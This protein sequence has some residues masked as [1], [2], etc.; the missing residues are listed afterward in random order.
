VQSDGKPIIGGTFFTI[1]GTGHGKLARLQSDGSLDT[2]FNAQTVG[3]WGGVVC[4]ALQPDGKILVGGDSLV[5]VNPDGSLDPSFKVNVGRPGIRALTLQPDGKVLIGGWF[6]SVNGV[7]LT[8]L[9]RLNSDGSLDTEF[10][11]HLQP[12]DSGVNGIAFQPDGEIFIGG[13]F[14]SV[15]GL[16]RANIARLNPD[17][18]PDSFVVELDGDVV[19]CCPLPNGQ[20]LVWGFFSFVNGV[21]HGFFARLNADGSLDPAFVG[22][23]NGDDSYTAKAVA[24][25]PDGKLLV[26]REVCNGSS[27]PYFVRLT[28]N[29]SFDDS[30]FA[31]QGGP[32]NDVDSLAV[33]PDGKILLGGVFSVVSQIPC[34]GM[35]RLT[36]D[37]VPP[38]IL[39][40]PGPQTAEVGS[41]VSLRVKAKSSLPLFYFWY[42]NSTNLISCST[43]WGVT[44]TNVQFAQSG[45]YSVAVSNALGVVTSAPAMLNVI[46]VVERR[47]VPGLTLTGERGSALNLETRA[48]MGPTPDWAPFDSVV[49]TNDS[50]WYFDL[51][52]PLPPQ[53]F[54]R[55]WQPGPSDVG[56]ALDLHMVPAITL[57]GSIGGSLRLDY[58]N[59]FGPTDAWVTL[60][61]VTLTSMSQLY[62]DI[63]APGQPQR[64]YRL[65]S[66]P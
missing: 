19:G 21:S 33:Q 23:R 51:S 10:V 37:S 18:S 13:E 45:A 25:Q 63:S 61:T 27:R 43:N 31:G 14:A 6:T 54:Y 38:T 8:A 39:V 12:A 3:G 4:L 22:G 62:F 17:G 30:F 57:R 58:I 28:A 60:D 53:R 2:S 15:N 56:S 24:L 41:V 34:S 47:W 36:G 16:S 66:L 32:D 46:S 7:A 52:A 50:Q 49:L 48:V 35:I 40:S 42:L 64:L 26:A 1:D 11:S 20:V 55:A 5:R 65:V 44:L 29:G 9:A 59:R